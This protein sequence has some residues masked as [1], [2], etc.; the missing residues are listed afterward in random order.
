MATGIIAEYNPF[1]NGHKYMLSQIREQFPHE[2]IIACISGSITQRGEMALL[3]KWTRAKIAVLAGI[4]LVIELPAVFACRSAQA[5]GSGGVRLLSATGVID[6]LAFGTEYPNL[7]QLSKAA[8]FEASLYPQELKEL[9]Q[10]GLSYGTAV[11]S[12]MQQKLDLPEAMLYE[13]N[14]ILG[15][16][17]L[18]CL[19]ELKSQG[20]PTPEPLLIT[21]KGT[22]HGDALPQGSFASGTA[23]RQLLAK[24][25]DKESLKKALMPLMPSA[26]CQAILNCQVYPQAPKIYH[27]LRYKLLDATPKEL[28]GIT[29]MSEGLEQSMLHCLNVGSYAEFVRQLTTR[30]YPSTRIQRLI[31]HTLLSMHKDIIDEMDRTGPLYLRVLAMDGIGR[32][33]LRQIKNRGRLPLLNNVPNILNRRDL[34]HPETLNMPQKMLAMDIAATNLRGLALEHTSCL[35]EDYVH[36]PCYVEKNLK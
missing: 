6:R 35:Y 32:Q 24:H 9:L 28:Q 15:L 20:Q 17:Y 8:E 29:G 25:T 31:V 33:L 27:L 5:F 16:E 10:K 34:L 30:R 26:G 12:L 23:I 7:A 4:N 21:R 19:N 2:P 13:P 18:R 36:S 11:T 14:T 3:D 1:H 22:S